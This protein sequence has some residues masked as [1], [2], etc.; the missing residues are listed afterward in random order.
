MNI[1]DKIK[2]VDASTLKESDHWSDILAKLIC[3][4]GSYESFFLE[5]RTTTRIAK[6]KAERDD[7]Y[8]LDL[9]HIEKTVDGNYYL[10]MHVTDHKVIQYLHI[11]YPHQ[12]TEAKERNNG[13][14][15]E[16]DLNELINKAFS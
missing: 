10:A 6:I 3:D 13:D 1:T 7:F 15:E 14:Y 16:F 4:R 12:L 5:M 2:L 9:D 11:I 8:I